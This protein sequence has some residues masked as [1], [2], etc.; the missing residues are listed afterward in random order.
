[1]AQL[2]V[3]PPKREVHDQTGGTLAAELAADL[4]VGVLF[5]WNVLDESLHWRVSFVISSEY[6]SDEIEMT[7][8]KRPVKRRAY[9]SQLRSEGAAETR[10]QVLAAA[11]HLFV[12][13][14][15]DAMTMRAIADRADVALDTVYETVGKKP[16]LAKLLIEAAISNEDRAVPAEQR[17]H[18]RRIQSTPDA[19]TK[20]ALYAAAVVDIHTRLAPLVRALQTAAPRHPDLA[21]M[22]QEISQR[23]A[24]NMRAFAADLIT[25][26]GTRKQLE[27]D[28]VADLLWALAAPEFYLL[29]VE[30]R[31]WTPAQ[32]EVWLGDAW[33]RLLLEDE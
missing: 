33:R 13:H 11:H 29:L 12:E 20:L 24:R 8:T 18:V 2:A 28:R 3:L 16:K 32:A 25:T 31:G 14:G 5:D 15:Y 27:R 19:R 17:D 23:R 21:A 7:R 30:Q 22:W 10:R 6:H 26:G 9:R 1:M 4:V